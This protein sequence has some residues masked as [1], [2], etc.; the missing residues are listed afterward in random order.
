[1]ASRTIQNIQT[2]EGNTAPPLVLTCQ[3]QGV[4]IN[5]TGCTVNLAIWQNNTILTNT[6]HQSCTITDEVNGIVTYVRQAGDI[7]TAGNY[8]CDIIV[9][10]G[11]ATLETLYTQVKLIVAKKSGS[12]T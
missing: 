5:L 2:V 3:R 11:D 7:P 4:A 1:M 10:Y 6:G 12:T 9:T 8:F